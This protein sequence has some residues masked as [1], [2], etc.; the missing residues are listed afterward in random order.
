FFPVPTASFKVLFVFILLAHERRRIIHFNITEHPTA[1]WTIQQIVEAFPWDTAPRYLLRDRDSIYGEHFQQHIKNMG[2]EE[3]KI[4]PRSPWQNP[5]CERLIGS[6]R[7]DV[8]DH[9]IVLNEWHLKRVLSAYIAY[10]HRFRTHLSLE[11]DCPHPRAVEPPEI[12]EVV[13]AHGVTEYGGL[14]DDWTL[15]RL[16]IALAD[17]CHRPGYG[18]THRRGDAWRVLSVAQPDFDTGGP[19]RT[20]RHRPV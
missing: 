13:S 1:Q 20:R 18:H 3:V 9:V 12:G 7:R 5:Y 19:L 15:G 6:I 11:M 16:R 10:Y 4:A 8:L 17:P 14:D 2:I